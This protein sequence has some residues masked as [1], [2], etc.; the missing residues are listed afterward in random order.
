MKPIVFLLICLLNSMGAQAQ[1]DPQARKVLDATASALQKQGG[2]QIQFTATTFQK[3][4]EQGCM[5]GTMLIKGKKFRLSTPDVTTWFDGK[6]QWSYLKANE[7]VNVSTPTDEELQTLNPYA[8]IALYKSGYDYTMKPT[9]T[10]GK[11]SYEI[12]LRAESNNQPIKTLLLDVEQ[13]TR[14]PLCVRI[15]DGQTWVRIAIN[16]VAGK[17]KFNDDVFRFNANDYPQAEIIDMR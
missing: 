6:T 9:T 10:Y 4:Q 7:E 16:S 15:Y 2:F 17:Q 1:K 8:F 14:M 3:G 13:A 12:K 11:A 5:S